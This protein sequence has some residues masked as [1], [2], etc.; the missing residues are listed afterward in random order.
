M[1]QTLAAAARRLNRRRDA[2]PALWLMT[3]ENRLP[4]P[5]PVLAALG[6]VGGGLILRYRDPT[7]HRRDI[8]RIRR[9]SRIVSVPVLL[10]GPVALARRFGLAGAHYAEARA[11]ATPGRPRRRLWL[12]CAAHDRRAL[13]RAARIG[14]DAAIVA[15][16]FATK[17]HPDARTLG[18]LRLARLIRGSAV[19]VIA[20]GG[21]DATTARRLPPRV[22]G[23]AAIGAL[24]AEL[25]RRCGR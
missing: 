4:D 21:I 1:P 22:A 16:V 7:A 5:T 18:P 3:D 15:P 12:T 9:L 19:P 20:L 14:A 25:S 24:A 11:R 2:L 13:A 23:I 10:A 8:A 6:R 17:S